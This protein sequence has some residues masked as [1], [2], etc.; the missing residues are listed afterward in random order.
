MSEKYCTHVETTIAE[1]KTRADRI[2]HAIG[3]EFPRAMMSASF[4]VKDKDRIAAQ[5]MSDFGVKTSK[6]R[7]TDVYAARIAPGRAESKNKSLDE[8]HELGPAP[9]TA[10]GVAGRAAAVLG[11][12]CVV[13]AIRVRVRN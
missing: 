2:R 9:G 5:D 10:A 11:T 4:R 12:L 3:G 7:V 13:C 1:L 6:T 8:I